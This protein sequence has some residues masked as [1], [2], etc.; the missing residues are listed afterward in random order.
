MK[1]PAR[2]RYLTL[3]SLGLALCLPAVATADNPTIVISSDVLIS[4]CRQLT[5]TAQYIGDD[6]RDGSTLIEY[7]TSDSWPGITACTN[8]TDSLPR[9]CLIPGLTPGG[10]YWVRVTFTDPDGVSG[11]N[12]E[13]LG[14]FTLGA[15]GADDVAP[16]AT[17]ITPSERTTI[18]GIDRIKVQVWDEGGLSA[19]PL[20]WWV[21]TNAPST[22][23]AINPNYDCGANCSVWE[24][25]VDWTVFARGIHGLTVEVTDAAG[26]TAR[27]VRT[28]SV[29]NSG[30]KPAGSGLLLRRTLGSQQ[31]MDCHNLPGHSSQFT[32]TT[33]GNWSAD[34]LNCHRAHYTLNVYLIEVRVL[35]PADG[36]PYITFWTDDAAGGTNPIRSY[37]GNRTPPDNEPWH[38]GICEACH[39]RTKY[40]RNNSSGDHSHHED[41]RCIN[42]HPHSSGFAAVESSGGTS[43]GG[44]HPNI[45]E[46]MNGT[47]AKTSRHSIGAVLGVNDA[48]TDTAAVWASPLDAISPA[49]RSCVN[50]CHQDHVHN[51][52]GGTSHDFN[53]HQDA[54]SPANR[55]VGRDIDGAIIA[56]TPARTDFDA[57]VVSGGMCTSCHQN[58]IGAAGPSID[59]PAYDLSA[60]DFTSNAF[61]TW[62]YSMHDGSD[63]ARNCTKCHAD[64]GDG[65]PS[66]SGLSLGAVHFSDFPKLLT[67]SIN[68]SGNTDEFV[69]YTCHGNAT[70]GID[71]SGKDLVTAVTK[72][73]NHP[74]E[75]DSIHDTL[76]EENAAFSDG[77]FSGTNRHVNCLDCHGPHQTQQGLHSPGV[78]TLAGALVGAGGIGIVSLPGEWTAFTASNFTTHPGQATAEYQI[79]FKC[80]SSFAYNTSPPTGETDQ[81]LEFNV[82]NDSYHWIMTDQAATQAPDWTTANDTPR[83]DSTNRSMTFSSGSPWAKDSP[84]VC[85]DCHGNDD[86]AGVQGPHGS[87]FTPLLTK[88]WSA[89]SG[90]STPD[91][92]CFDCHDFQTYAGENTN[93]G[94]SGFARSGGSRN[95][96]GSHS[97]RYPTTW[98]CSWCHSTIPHGWNRKALVILDG[99]PAPYNAGGNT[100][101]ITSWSISNTRQ[102]QRSS[103]GTV[104][105]ACH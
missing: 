48:F 63:F 83:T 64:R 66:A 45:W 12:P 28:V 58:S 4:S 43:C 86:S 17:F 101:E 72:A 8:I 71:L 19:S 60:H 103:C 92:L 73:S 56:G 32:G 39:T 67:G 13:V 36:R 77:T 7:N 40:H 9:Q 5:A 94:V 95:L 24:F 23:A 57:G 21:D 76:N 87:A 79:C 25:D 90:I 27:A 96:H 97:A 70:T 74:V 75:S 68:P 35:T 47:N 62:T 100:A 65:R 50:M 78:S 52:P 38:D 6:N 29:R 105:S 98:S 34:C 89:T 99:D 80:H 44:C 53:V 93:L 84:M 61:G 10:D 88:A 26:N 42:C 54:S 16:T 49:D 82:N 55:V 2:C 69:C 3:F 41:R 22:T 31:C 51:T 85:S 102:Y 81:A 37:L 18:G 91:G 1:N 30:S 11:P 46:G 104:T 59:A 15:C 20:S 14:P 33:Y